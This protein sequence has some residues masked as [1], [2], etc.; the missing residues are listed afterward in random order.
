MAF[1][2]SE[3]SRIRRLLSYP[4][5]V[6]LAQSVQ[7]GYPAASQPAFLVDDA[8]HRLTP[9]AEQ[10]TRKDLAECECIE[11]QI[12]DARSRLKATRLGELELNPNELKQL[13]YELLWWTT[14][15]ADDLGVV[16]DPYSQMIYQALNNQGGMSARV[17]G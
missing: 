2:E 10:L 17:Q 6:S 16:P 11:S 9:E 7:L 12:S 13:R 4:S 1:S 15:L 3:K 5:W 8:F 14:R